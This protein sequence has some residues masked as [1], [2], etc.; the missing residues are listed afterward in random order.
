MLDA[1]HLLVENGRAAFIDTGTNYSVP[2][3]LDA[4]A[5]ADI[6][7]GDV[8]YVILTHIHLDHAGGAGLLMQHLPNAR[9]AVHPRGARHI[10]GPEK[11][12]AGTEAV[13]GVEETR[14]MYGEIQPIDE[15]RLLVPDDGQVIELAGRP[16][17]VL[18]TL[19]HAK[20]HYCIQDERSQSVFT[21]DSFGISY[22]EFDTEKGAF[23]YPTTTPIH[24]DPPEAH[25]AIDRIMA[26]EPRQV[27]LT[28]YSRVQDLGR[29]A[30]DLHEAIDGFVAFATAHADDDDRAAKI[31]NEMFDFLATGL[32]EHGF[33][34]DRDAMYTLLEPD[35]VLNT[36]GLEFWLDHAER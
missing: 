13:Y 22:R 7:V 32:E 3:L 36:Q 8:D 2:L 29:L 6:D 26:C 28:H 11:L 5:S 33:E 12:I 20:H 14:R 16:L 17:R 19:G 24:F 30:S 4:L 23:I 25:K 10:A 21:G 1:S 35:L 18:Y 9:C 34:G 31:Q 27:F 15:K